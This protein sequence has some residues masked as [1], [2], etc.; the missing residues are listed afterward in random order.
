MSQLFS[1]LTIRTVEVRN[2]LWVAPMC[3][4]SAQDG[5]PN[6]WHHVHLAQFASGG[7]GLVMAEATAVVPEGRITPEDTGIWNDEQR[8]AWRPIVTAIHDRGAVAAIQLAHAGRKASTYSPFA[9]ERGTVPEAEGGWQALA[10]S[11]VAFDGYARPDELE[12]AEIDALVTA[13]ADGAR[14]SREAGFDVLEIH[15]AH[16]YLLHEF[17]SPLSNQRTD[18]YGGSLENR[19]RLL[20]LIVEAVRAAAPDAPLFVRFS[21]TDWAEGG[22]DVAETATVSAWAHERGADLIDVSSGGLVAH[23]RITTGPGYQ[24]PF[25]SQIRATT[26]LPVS[27]VGEI[28]TGTQAEEILAAGDADAIMAGREW[29]RDPHFGLRAADELGEDASV[30]PPQYVRARRR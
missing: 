24:V 17:L 15:A 25:A 13:F 26:G 23:Q 19:A 28:T 11:A 4:Y 6:D 10:P 5:M 1:P 3:Q 30:W 9:A 20:L 27:A 21:A 18:E 29:L 22:W 7:A 12:R 16:G 2:R 8:D 14:R